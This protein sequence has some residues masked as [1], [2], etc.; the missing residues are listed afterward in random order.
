MNLDFRLA[1]AFLLTGIFALL[2]CQDDIGQ[3]HG[4]TTAS[5]ANSMSGS[6]SGVNRGNSSPNASSNQQTGENNTGSSS[7]FTPEQEASREEEGAWSNMSQ[8]TV[9]PP[10]RLDDV[11]DNNVYFCRISY[12]AS[13]I[14]ILEVK[15][16]GDIVR[17]CSTE[18]Y[19]AYSYT[20]WPLKVERLKHL[21][22]APLPTMF[23]MISF[24]AANA[25]GLEEGKAYLI[26]LVEHDGEVYGHGSHLEVIPYSPEQES[27]RIVFSGKFE[28]LEALGDAHLSGQGQSQGC[29]PGPL[30]S[31][32]NYQSYYLERDPELC[33]KISARE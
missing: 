15:Q 24:D 21:A 27:Y 18:P 3:G 30:T 7:G 22:G 11:E 28:A 29:T 4:E 32:E 25:P 8:V 2:G 13:S 16:A 17:A 33:E 19:N 20:Y 23:D 1:C 10:A 12:K 6:H 9:V 31:F 5:Q 26:G 14:V